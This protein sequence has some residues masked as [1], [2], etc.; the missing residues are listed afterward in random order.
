MKKTFLLA[1]ALCMLAAVFSFTA[2]AAEFDELLPV[3]VVHHS[4]RLEIRKI[5]E[6][7]A[8]ADPGSIPRSDFERDNTSYTCADILREVVIGEITRTHIETVSVESEKNNIE[9]IMNLLSPQI[10]IV[11]E[12]GFFGTLHLS[13]SSIK[14]EASGYGSSSS[15]VTVTRQ[16]PNF[17][18]TDTQHIPKEV[19]EG[20][21]TYTLSD[22][23]WRTDNTYNVDDYEIGNRYTAI[24][25]Y[26]GTRTTSYVKGYNVTAD[27]IGE[28]CRTG[29]S[30][31]R[32][33]V[34][35]TGAEIVRPEPE[36]AP[37]PEP[38]PEPEP[39]P[40]ETSGFNWMW[41]VIPLI[42]L[43][44]A[45]IGG[46]AYM[47]LNNRKEQEHHAENTDYDYA[48]AYTGDGGDDAGGGNG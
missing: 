34:I 29:V 5:Y 37:T 4:E 26:S 31:I 32:Y 42:M 20:G 25:T 19:T 15:K 38:E 16:Y 30:V 47:Y 43:T 12:D 2:S 8:S 17:S 23:Q 36:P 40:V 39:L 13:A 1:A 41:V 3:D 24:A 10:E 18:S 28:I 46:L 35:F 22:V 45:S 6:L 9:T 14:T 27:Y 21:R 48:D 7:P 11:T 33:T 44:L